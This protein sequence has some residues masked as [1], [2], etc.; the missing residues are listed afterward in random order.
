LTEATVSYAAPREDKLDAEV[1]ILN[2]TAVSA[3]SVGEPVARPLSAGAA[4]ISVG[5]RE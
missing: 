5:N 3:L 2:K 1:A 4:P